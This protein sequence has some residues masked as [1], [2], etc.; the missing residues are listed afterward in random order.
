MSIILAKLTIEIVRLGTTHI[1]VFLALYELFSDVHQSSHR[2]FVAF[3]AFYNQ[4]MPSAIQLRPEGVGCRASVIDGIRLGV[5][6]NRFVGAVIVP[7]ADTEITLGKNKPRIV[8]LLGQSLFR[9][10]FCGIFMSTDLLMTYIHLRL[11]CW[12]SWNVSLFFDLGV[13]LEQ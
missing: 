1:Y 2:L 11:T 6:L 4:T 5:S 10:N 3:W 13:S 7:V 9:T 12:I 8:C